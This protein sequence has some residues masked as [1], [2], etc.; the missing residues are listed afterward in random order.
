MSELELYDRI[1]EIGKRILGYE[2]GNRLRILTELAL[3]TLDKRLIQKKTTVIDD[4]RTF[5]Y[6][7]AGR[8][9]IPALERVTKKL[10]KLGIYIEIVKSENGAWFRGFKWSEHTQQDAL[11]TLKI[12]L[13]AK[14]LIIKEKKEDNIWIL[15]KFTSFNA[16]NRKPK[17]NKRVFN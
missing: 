13:A 6:T 7:S 16:R 15:R 17:L 1:D 2:V 12:E 11:E 3:N 10:L 8:L 9:L 5:L 14:G 4:Q